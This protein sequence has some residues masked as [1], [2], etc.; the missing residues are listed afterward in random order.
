MGRLPTLVDALESQYG[1]PPA[2]YPTD[3]FELV[4][5]EN[6]AY[7][8]NDA[9]RREA[10]EELRRT[11]GLDPMS[12]YRASTAQLAAVTRRGALADAFA[13]KLHTA[14]EIA[15]DEL[16]GDLDE[17]LARPAPAAKRALRRFPGIGEPGAE[18]ILLFCRAHP[19]LAVESN[20]LRVLVRLGL[21]AE[22]KSYAST[23]ASA[24]A[25]GEEELGGDFDALLRARALLR[26]HG[27]ETCRQKAPAC[28]ACALRA[29]CPSATSPGHA[30]LAPPGTRRA[31]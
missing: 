25:L 28:D 11:V 29:D 14:A 26:Q 16:G 9:T 18:K 1:P 8:A 13:E 15:L 5:W 6:V 22:G 3:P 20:G 7:L 17:V 31:R 23:Y 4:V 12:I 21:C 2:P 19:F 10:L 24:R 27:R 30:P